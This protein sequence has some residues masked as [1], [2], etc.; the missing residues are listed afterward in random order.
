MVDKYNFIITNLDAHTIDLEPFQYSGA[1]ITIMRVID[2]SSQSLS[3]YSEYL[4]KTAET[5]RPAS[6]GDENAP[7][8][9]DTPAEEEADQPTEDEP[10]ENKEDD[11]T[12][13]EPE[14]EKKKEEQGE[15][16]GE[17]TLFDADLN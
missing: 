10:T 4:K 11:Q 16:E 14:E 13:S 7:E 6:E 17:E 12:P 8:N 5:E 15:E 9:S 2:T 3:D 1:N